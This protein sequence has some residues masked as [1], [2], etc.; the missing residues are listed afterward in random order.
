MKN[1]LFKGLK[2][3]GLAACMV[4]GVSAVAFT[5]QDYPFITGETQNPN[6]FTLFATSGW[7][8]NWYVGYNSCWISKLPVLPQRKF[9]KAF[10]GVK[11]GRMKTLGV[12]GTPTWVRK[13]I[14]GEIWVAVS[15]THAWDRSNSYLL[16]TTEDIPWEGDPQNALEGVG[17]AQWFWVEVPIEKISF[18]E[19]NYIAVWSPTKELEDITKA[20]VIAAGWGSRVVNTWLNTGIKGVPPAEPGTALEK[21]V[22]VFEPAIAIKLIPENVYSLEVSIVG[23]ER[24]TTLPAAQVVTLSVRGSNVVSAWLEVSN[25]N[26]SSW[27]RCTTVCYKPPYIFTLPVNDLPMGTL[28]LRG[29]AR[30]IFEN[31]GYSPV[32]ELSATKEI[33]VT[34]K[35]LSGNELTEINDPEKDVLF[36]VSGGKTEKMFYQVS[37]DKKKWETF[38]E[39]VEF[40]QPWVFKFKQLKKV[41]GQKKECYVKFG[42]IDK[43]GDKGSSKE[44]VYNPQKLSSGTEKKVPVAGE[45]IK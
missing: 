17:E 7:D 21:P 2:L 27:N 9:A 6:E 23:T 14:P 40:S 13:S 3:F 38:D 22:T 32:L 5:Q 26:G 12:I 19:H 30:D 4:F 29:G 41:A 34:L 10:I 39:T 11:L 43:W 36:I 25:N 44:I 35:D 33:F 42:V 31:Y 37:T 45:E 24:H 16:T 20:P 8:G 1:N 18:P 15:S 28:K